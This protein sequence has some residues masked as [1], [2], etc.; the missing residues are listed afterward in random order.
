MPRK[1][2]DASIDK[3]RLENERLKSDLKYYKRHFR[4]LEAFMNSAP[5]V[6]YIKNQER[7][8]SYFNPVRERQFGLKPDDI[9]WHTDRD[10]AGNPWSFLAH[11]QDGK[12]LASNQPAE[13]FESSPDA[14]DETRRNWLV[15]RFPFTG[16][17]GELC[18]GAVGLDTSRHIIR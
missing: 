17:D 13:T 10:L 5:F 1:K 2:A 12:V 9:L 7:Q 11:E 4:Q 6:I 8:Y 15:V 16:P 3:L 18:I 14:E